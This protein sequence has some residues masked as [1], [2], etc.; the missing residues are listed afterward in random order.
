MFTRKIFIAVLIPWSLHSNFIL[1]TVE[2]LFGFWFSVCSFV[3]CFIKNIKT[4]NF[5]QLKNYVSHTHQTLPLYD[6]TASWQKFLHAVNVAKIIP[7]LKII[8]QLLSTM[9]EWYSIPHHNRKYFMQFWLQC[10][11]NWVIIMYYI[12]KPYQIMNNSFQFSSSH[13]VF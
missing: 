7:S 9:E 12:F 13:L 10:K 4:L 6:D 1:S 8:N 5:F 3:L 2:N 11:L